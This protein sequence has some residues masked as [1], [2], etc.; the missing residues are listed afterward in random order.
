MTDTINYISSRNEEDILP[1]LDQEVTQFVDF[2]VDWIK[3]SWKG[4]VFNSEKDD[5][6]ELSARIISDIGLQIRA[7]LNG[8][9]LEKVKVLLNN[10]QLVLQCFLKSKHIVSSIDE[11]GVASLAL[12]ALESCIDPLYFSDCELRI[13]FGAV[14]LDYPSARVP[15]YIVAAKNIL[16][17][18]LSTRRDLEKC[19]DMVYFPRSLPKVMLYS[20]VNLVNQVNEGDSNRVRDTSQLNFALIQSYLEEF[21]DSD[22]LKQFFFD[23]DIPIKEGSVLDLQLAFY[24]RILSLI[25][26]PSFQ[27]V[28]F[29]VLKMGERYRSTEEKSLRYAAAH[30]IFSND[31]IAGPI[32]QSLK[33]T[34]P[35]LDKLIMLGGQ[36]EKTFYRIRYCLE[37]YPHL[38][39]EAMCFFKDKIIAGIPS[40][41]KLYDM[42]Q[43]SSVQTHPELLYRRLQLISKVGDKSVYGRHIGDWNIKY[44]QQKSVFDLFTDLQVDSL[45]QLRRELL[46]ILSDI[47]GISPDNGFTFNIE[48]R[49]DRS[50]FFLF[51]DAYDKYTRFCSDF[52]TKYC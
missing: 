1:T 19:T 38:L 16:E 12:I 23:E 52:L 6:K 49:Y 28:K 15:A 13:G 27:D 2:F 26:D 47:S 48:K 29:R 14:E 34:A 5:I 33:N 7:R 18:L 11:D 51:G 8:F 32:V 4:H 41:Q 20:V 36:P 44:L 30:A 46:V 40:A 45:V 42:Y 35:R 50:L 24:V 9:P 25:R 22:I 31:L 39:N 37:H 21:A 17:S 3:K 10:T 43:S